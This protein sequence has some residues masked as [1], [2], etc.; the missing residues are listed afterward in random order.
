MTVAPQSAEFT[1]APIELGT[2]ELQ[3][4]RIRAGDGLCPA[5]TGTP[6]YYYVEYRQ[7]VGWDARFGPDGIFDGAMIYLGGEIDRTTVRSTLLLDMHPAIGQFDFVDS[8][9]HL[10]QTFTDFNGIQIT[11]V[12][13]S[14]QRLRVRVQV[15]GGNGQAT[16]VASPVTA[17]FNLSSQSATQYCGDIMVRNNTA[18]V[19]SNW[20]VDVDLRQSTLL[21]NWNSVF[22]SQGGSLYAVTPPSWNRFIQP[23]QSVAAGMCASK[24]GTNFLPLIL[25]ASGS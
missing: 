18:A 7:P 1:L 11:A 16:C 8:A 5:V 15:P 19:I 9:L 2:T 13:Q 22:T 3:A 21:N 12:S 23:G 25:S 24:T 4:L 17:T 10:G 14:A 20:R 6:C